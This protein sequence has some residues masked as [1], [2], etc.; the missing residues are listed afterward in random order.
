MRVIETWTT[1]HVRALLDLTPTIRLFELVP[2]VGSPAQIPLGGHINITVMID[3]QADTRSYSLI[4]PPL[5]DA[6]RIAVKLTPD[7]RGGSR[8][9]WSL[10]EGSQLTISAPRSHFGI[11][12]GR[13]DYLLVAGGIGITPIA[14]TAIALA[15]SGAKMQLLYC[16]RTRGELALVDE[17]QEALGDR[18]Q[19]FIS[20][21]GQRLD[22]AAALSALGP[23]GLAAIC[24]PLRML[25]DARRVW[26]N[27]GRPLPDLRYETFG[28]SGTLATETFRV[29]IAESGREIMV[30]ETQSILDAL[31]A[32][33]IGVISDCRRGECG[34]CALNIVEVDGDVDHRDVFFSEH[35]K[36]GNSKICACVSRAVGTI[37]IDPLLR[38]DP[39]RPVR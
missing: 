38:P 25:D 10:G 11:D 21:E 36:A 16:A 28:S 2:A 18:V 22:L 20:D 1:A 37:T 29:R 17:L 39:A 6:Y 35:Q 8:Y 15:R 34:V 27:L 4:G 24:G 9:M 7:S 32:A 23:D 13:P 12:F 26:R 19:F 5:P 30:P 31:E 33:G 3:G 14:G